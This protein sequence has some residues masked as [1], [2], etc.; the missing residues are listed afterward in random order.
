[1]NNDK[2]RLNPLDRPTVGREAQELAAELQEDYIAARERDSGLVYRAEFTAMMEAVAVPLTE[3][4]R[5]LRVAADR[6]GATQDRDKEGP[7]R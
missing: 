7:D 3:Y 6:A 4:E 2:L 5:A 1:M